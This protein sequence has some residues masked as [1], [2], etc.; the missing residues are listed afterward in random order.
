M[1]TVQPAVSLA[2]F[3]EAQMGMPRF[4]RRISSRAGLAFCPVQLQDVSTMRWTINAW[5][6]K[7]EWTMAR[8][9]CALGNGDIPKISPISV[10]Q[11]NQFRSPP[12][13]AIY[14][15]R[16]PFSSD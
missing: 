2:L 14:L 3:P 16:Q 5:A 15:V 12:C 4:V 8:W 6:R 10:N 1:A 7:S 13:E 9:S 11:E